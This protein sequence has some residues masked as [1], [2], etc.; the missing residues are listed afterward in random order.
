MP[1]HRTTHDDAPALVE[2]LEAEG[3]TCTI[4]TDDGGVYVMAS[5]P[6]TARRKGGEPETR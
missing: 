1:L 3:F 2:K 6:S 4:S 5:K